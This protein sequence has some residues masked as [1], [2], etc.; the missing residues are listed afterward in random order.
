MILSL[1]GGDIT[2]YDEIKFGFDVCDYLMQQC[3]KKY[4]NYCEQF[5]LKRTN[6]NK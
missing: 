1:A 4:E 3:Y 6:S 5:F 2:K